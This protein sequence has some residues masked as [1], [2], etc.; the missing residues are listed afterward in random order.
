MPKKIESHKQQFDTAA[1]LL[2]KIMIEQVLCRRASNLKK[3]ENK[4]GK[5]TK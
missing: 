4:Y 3:I 1:E 5:S 2:A